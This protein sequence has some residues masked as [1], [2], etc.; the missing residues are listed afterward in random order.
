MRVYTGGAKMTACLNQN[1]CS[2]HPAARQLALIDHHLFKI[3]NPYKCLFTLLLL[4][5]HKNTQFFQPAARAPYVH[6]FTSLQLMTIFYL[7][8]WT[9]TTQWSVA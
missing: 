6:S 8:N 7:K 3:N 2:L 1:G 4:S 5:S 9:L